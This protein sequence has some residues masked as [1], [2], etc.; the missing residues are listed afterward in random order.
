MKSRAQCTE[1]VISQGLKT[2]LTRSRIQDETKTRW[3]GRK[4]ASETASGWSD[5]G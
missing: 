4:S 5:T 1:R 2:R 3:A